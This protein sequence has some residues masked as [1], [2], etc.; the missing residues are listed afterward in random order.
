[1]FHCQKINW[2]GNGNGNTG[3]P[4]P[5]HRNTGTSEHRNTGTP[6][7]LYRDRYHYNQLVLRI[8]CYNKCIDSSQTVNNPP[9]KPTTNAATAP[10]TPK[11]TIAPIPDT[12]SNSDAALIEIDPNN[13]A[14]PSTI[15]P[16]SPSHPLSNTNPFYMMNPDNPPLPT[17]SPYSLPN[18]DPNIVIIANCQDSSNEPKYTLYYNTK[19]GFKHRI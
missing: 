18:D 17:D 9:S 14:F 10:I 13:D 16:F 3:T 5:E 2:N 8:P 12:E 4:E 7:W 1:M 15:N 6:E 19:N 11:P